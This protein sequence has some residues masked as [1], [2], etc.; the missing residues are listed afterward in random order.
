MARGGVGLCPLGSDARLVPGVFPNVWWVGGIQR[1][2]TH[3]SVLASLHVDR[4]HGGV[5]SF[6]RS[7]IG[8]GSHD[9]FLHVLAIHSG[10]VVL[11]QLLPGDVDL[12]YVLPGGTISGKTGTECR[13]PE[14]P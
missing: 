8:A 10:H 11:S 14:H 6:P 12:V 5:D 2:I 4:D 13:A 7:F 9:A 1:E 3:T